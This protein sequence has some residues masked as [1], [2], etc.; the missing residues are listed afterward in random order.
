M[1]RKINMKKLT[2]ESGEKSDAN[3]QGKCSQLAAD[4]CSMRH[5]HSVHIDAIPQSSEEC[6]R[7]VV[8][9]LRRYG[10]QTHT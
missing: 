4:I 1:N 9:A 7:I 10:S 6:V 8:Y 2:T 5:K 3:A